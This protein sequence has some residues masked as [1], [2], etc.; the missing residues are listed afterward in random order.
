MG[1]IPRNSSGFFFAL[2]LHF[3]SAAV[4]K[5]RKVKVFNTQQPVS[6]KLIQSI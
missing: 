5:L 2:V 1:H 4:L 6:F 3:Y